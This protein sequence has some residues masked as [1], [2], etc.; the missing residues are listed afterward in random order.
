[1]GRKLTRKVLGHLLVRFII[2]LL[3]TAQLVIRYKDIF[4][5]QDHGEHIKYSLSIDCDHRTKEVLWTNGKK[6]YHERKKTLRPCLC[7]S[8]ESKI[9]LCA[10]MIVG[11]EG[12]RERERERE[13]E[14]VRERGV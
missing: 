1:M 10:M 14:R 12:K 5:S 9:I 7:Q 3:R 13:R 11:G 6:S 8:I 4:Y 2:H